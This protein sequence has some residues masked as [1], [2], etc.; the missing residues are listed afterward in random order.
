MCTCLPSTGQGTANFLCRTS[1]FV[2]VVLLRLSLAHSVSHGQPA[3][4]QYAREGPT[5]TFSEY[6]Y[7]AIH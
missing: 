4:V 7:I 6:Y 5:W 3:I 2:M 1:N